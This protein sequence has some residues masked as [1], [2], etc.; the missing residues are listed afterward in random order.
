M[1]E[2]AM[3]VCVCECLCVCVTGCVFVFACAS[4]VC[5]L[6]SLGGEW[7]MNLKTMQETKVGSQELSKFIS[8]DRGEWGDL[9]YILRCETLQP[10]KRPG[11]I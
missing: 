9:A 5:A 4:C 1:T 10:N 6:C 7:L 2:Y 3:C 8:P 11:R